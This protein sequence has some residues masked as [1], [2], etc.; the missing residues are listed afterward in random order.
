VSNQFQR[1]GAAVFV[2]YDDTGNLD[3]NDS[4]EVGDLL[5]QEVL[6]CIEAQNQHLRVG[7]C[8]E[9]VECCLGRA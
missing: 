8:E 7:G 2:G 5:L 9:M 1:C 4:L 3:F 6:V